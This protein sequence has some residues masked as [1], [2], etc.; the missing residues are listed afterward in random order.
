DEIT[1]A[2]QL[3]QRAR[4]AHA[5][6]RATP[7]LFV[8]VEVGT[9]QFFASKGREIFAL[10]KI[11]VPSD[12]DPLKTGE[13]THSNVI[14]LRQQERVNEVAAIYRELRII[15]RFLGYLQS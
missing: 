8:I 10:T 12:I 1:R 7:K 5:A 3:R 4:L 14:K 13:R 11:K 2:Q 6:K 9:L 15:D